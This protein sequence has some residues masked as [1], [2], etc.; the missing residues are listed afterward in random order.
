L[1]SPGSE[2]N[3][4]VSPDGRYL[5]FQAYRDIDAVGG[6]DLYV[7]ER[8]DFGWGPA[9]LLP[10]PINSPENDGYPRFSPDGRYLFFASDRA[11]GGSW[12]IYY[13]ESSAAGF[14]VEEP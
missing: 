8:T 6:E 7:A 10:E 2:T 9:R 14:D 4:A 12:S 5:L 13:V 1:N 3:P 11:P